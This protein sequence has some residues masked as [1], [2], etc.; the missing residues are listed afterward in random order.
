MKLSIKLVFLTA[1]LTAFSIII[2]FISV[3]G[4]SSINKDVKDISENWLPTIK[5]VG[6][7]N[8]MV[9]E[10]RRNEL[11]HILATDESTMRQYENKIQSLT[12][13]INEKV[14]EYE[15]LISEPEEKVAYPKF[16]AAWKAYTEN[17]AK[18]E[19]LSKSNK[20][21]EAVKLVLGPARA[22]YGEALDQLKIIIDVNDKGSKASA[23]DAEASYEQGKLITISLIIAVMLA[24]TAISILIIRGVTKQLG[25]DPGYLHYVASEIAGGQL[26]LAFKPYSG[27]GGVYGV[28]IKMVGNLKAKIAEAD[29][30]S[31]QAEQQ[32]KAAQEATALA[33]EATR[34]AERAKA[35][36]MLQAAQQL[37]GIVQ[38][39]SS[40]SEALSDQIAQSSR[41]ADEQ[42]GR[43]RET[44]TAMEEMNATVLEVAKNAQQAA[45]VSHQTREQAEE[46][47]QI[48]N[49]AVK[50]IESVHT[51]SIAI[52]EDMDA[53][54]KQAES[55]GQIMGVIADIADQT[56]LL[57]LNAAIE[58]ARAGDAGRGFA[59][60][61][62]EVRK[63][64]EKTMS[65]TQEVGQAIT[66]IQTGTRKNI[67][68]VEQVADTIE[69]ATNMSVRSGESLKKILELVH[70]VNDQVQ[71]IATASEQ[72]S[73]ASE[74]I[75]QS[76]EQVA[77]ISAQTAQAMEQA[78]GAVADL[79]Q[80]AQSLQQVI[81][82]MKNQS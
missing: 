3:I 56:N 68:N 66:G 58:A 23:V 49:E 52:K 27:D 54:G 79:T 63:L 42:S 40:A 20:T 38:I 1:L 47:S 41:G 10:Y 48:L 13:S 53:L 78:S 7:L 35:E 46:G 16:L 30:K 67:Q 80:Q 76:V 12:G 77:T 59:V 39:V 71:S 36:G 65:A 33:E 69:G 11:V 43:V 81:E 29:S 26:D 18:V 19:V 15:K 72:Q 45:D 75:N 64:A 60:V 32:A 37:E 73:A 25:E 8:S 50:G 62:D 57:A 74:E 51:Q 5:V 17:H 82:K 31:Q 61:A 2:G 24:A 21:E 70:L 44:A 28:L 55:I 22:Q 34:R 6:E 9:N 4:M 14:K